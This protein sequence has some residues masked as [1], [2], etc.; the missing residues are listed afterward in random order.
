[1]F[2]LNVKDHVVWVPAEVNLG[3]AYFRRA[4]PHDLA[5]GVKWFEKAAAQGSAVAEEQLAFA[6]EHGLGVPQDY[7]KALQWY[8][9][10]G[11]HGLVEAQFALGLMYSMGRG[12]PENRAL[13]K[14]WFAK[15][16][17]ADER[18][19]DDPRTQ[20][21]LGNTMAANASP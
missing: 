17:A 7:V 14:Q 16:A 3:M 20:S 12:T 13:A 15:A 1:L 6:Y 9:K 11:D 8:R 5:E 2:F 19:T 18:S 4:Q 21:S 10:A